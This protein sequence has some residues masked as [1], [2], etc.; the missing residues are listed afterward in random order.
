MH[1]SHSSCHSSKCRKFADYNLVRSETM[2]ALMTCVE[3]AQE[4]LYSFCHYQTHSIILQ[5][6]RF[7][8]NSELEQQ[9]HSQLPGQK[10]LCDPDMLH[11][12]GAEI[13][14]YVCQPLCNCRALLF[15]YQY[16]TICLSAQSLAS[17]FF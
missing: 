13:Y 10:L 6:S 15:S 4:C 2:V 12:P 14:M 16:L 9:C 7:Q 17:R 1:S 5:A 3:Y 8:I 11:G